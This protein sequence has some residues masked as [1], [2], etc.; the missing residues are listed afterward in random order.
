M[1]VDRPVH[2][3]IATVLRPTSATVFASQALTVAA[4]AGPPDWAT[5]RRFGLGWR[6]W[7]MLGDFNA[8]FAVVCLLGCLLVYLFRR[9]QQE[10]GL[11]S[12]RWCAWLNL[13]TIALLIC[14]PAIAAI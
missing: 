9:S 10:N 13:A 3:A 4:T 8:K 11:K 5:W 7:M 1:Q 2:E 12:T 6:V 14:V